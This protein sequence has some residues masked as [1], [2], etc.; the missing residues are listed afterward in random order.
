[1]RRGG[2]PPSTSPTRLQRSVAGPRIQLGYGGAGP[3]GGG[4]LAMVAAG[5]ENGVAGEIS[6][7]GLDTRAVRCLDLPGCARMAVTI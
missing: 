5:E 1:M 3:E 6:R 4:G 2:G 7:G